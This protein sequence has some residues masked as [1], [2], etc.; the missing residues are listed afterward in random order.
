MNL[1]SMSWNFYGSE[2][3]KRKSVSVEEGMEGMDPYGRIEGELT[4]EKSKEKS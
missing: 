2:E 1:V 3:G 4:C